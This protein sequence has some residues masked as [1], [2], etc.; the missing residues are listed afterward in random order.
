MLARL[1]DWN[2]DKEL[3]LVIFIL[4]RLSFLFKCTYSWFWKLSKLSSLIFYF[5]A[6]N[7]IC[8]FFRGGG[9]FVSKRNCE[10]DWAPARMLFLCCWTLFR[11]ARIVVERMLFDSLPFTNLLIRVWLFKYGW[12]IIININ[13]LEIQ[14]TDNLFYIIK[15]LNAQFISLYYFL[16]SESICYASIPL[17]LHFFLF[18]NLVYIKDIFFPLNINYPNIAYL[19][20]I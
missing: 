4:L 9:V 14:I 11:S 2:F 1:P 8:A 3:S 20:I 18:V 13:C 19:G 17:F 6:L 16:L 12:D 10:F 5:S 15:V 7:S